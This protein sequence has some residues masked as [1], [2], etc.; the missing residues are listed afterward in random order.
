MLDTVQYVY[1]TVTKE[2]LTENTT[3]VAPV[4]LE[5]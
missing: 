3:N 1:S 4:E 5:S 2:R